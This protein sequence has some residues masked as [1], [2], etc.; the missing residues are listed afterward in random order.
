MVYQQGAEDK[1][2]L[3][4]APE[5]QS[6]A[7]FSRL[8]ARRGVTGRRV[9]TGQQCLEAAA[10]ESF[11]LILV[12]IPI[13]DLSVSAL[14]TGL[15]Q[16]FSLNGDTPLLLLAGGKQYEAAES[17]RTARIQ[18]IDIDSPPAK[19][20]RLVTATLGVALR[21]AARLNIEL[22]VETDGEAVRRRCRTHDISRSGML[23][24][25]PTPLPIGTEFVFNFT[26]PE[27][28]TPIH[29]RA[30]VVRHTSERES[31][32]AGMGVRFIAFPEGAEEAI[33][34]FVKQNRLYSP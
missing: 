9:Q 10:R 31:L 4:L 13:A 17:Y 26:L 25:S 1:K 7:L 34:N 22:A 33:D 30:Q 19:I 3:I 18:V 28:F 27:R 29:G 12:R 16:R 14:A 32:S 2:L 24:E 5:D 11:D 20:E 6:S 21:T 8:L 23:L 15:A